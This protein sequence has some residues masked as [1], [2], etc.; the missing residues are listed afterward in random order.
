[1]RPQS[2]DS[3][4]PLSAKLAAGSKPRDRDLRREALTMLAR[5]IAEAYLEEVAR[6]RLAEI[7]VKP[8]LY[9]E[10]IKIIINSYYLFNR[11]VYIIH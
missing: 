8:R 1:M 9:V 3:G 4:E 6:K 10:T 7:G 5:M 2:C 11:K